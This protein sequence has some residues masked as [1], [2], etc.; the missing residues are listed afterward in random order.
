[1]VWAEAQSVGYKDCP[2]IG[3]QASSYMADLMI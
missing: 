2:D 1:M 3:R